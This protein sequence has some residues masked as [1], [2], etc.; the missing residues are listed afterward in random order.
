MKAILKF[1][2]ILSVGLLMMAAGCATKEKTTTTEKSPKNTTAVQEGSKT[3][4][5][6]VKEAQVGE[7][8]TGKTI[9]T[10]ED[11]NKKLGTVKRKGKTKTKELQ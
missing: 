8:V 3:S 6:A 5:R 2:A 4:N 11:S 1:P 9:Q 7:N 10:G